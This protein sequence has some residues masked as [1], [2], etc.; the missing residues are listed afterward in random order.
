MQINNILIPLLLACQAVVSN[1]DKKVQ[2]YCFCLDTVWILPDEAGSTRCCLEKSL[3]TVNKKQRKNYSKAEILRTVLFM[4]L[5]AIKYSYI[6]MSYVYVSR[7][8][9]LSNRIHWSAECY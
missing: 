4:L 7:G 2:G 6:A 3:K 1:N 5:H 8:K 9:I